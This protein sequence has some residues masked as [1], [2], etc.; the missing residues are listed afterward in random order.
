MQNRDPEPAAAGIDWATSGFAAAARNI[1][2]FAEEI[3]HIS[4]VSFTQNA[5]L[6]DE[7]SH[8]RDIGDIVTIQTKFMTGMFDT[9]NDQVRAMMSRMTDLPAGIGKEAEDLAQVGVEAAHSAAAVAQNA[10]RTAVDMARATQAST[11][12]AIA[13]SRDI[14]RAGVGAAQAAAERAGNA[15]K[16]PPSA[17]AGEPEA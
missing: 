2:V 5:K 8:A 3:A 15:F 14:A 4:R 13:A 16:A 7:L 10:T 17:F 1:Q 12:S 6:I 11:D 9:F